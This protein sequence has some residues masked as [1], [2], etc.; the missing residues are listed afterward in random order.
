MLWVSSHER[1]VSSSL[2][3]KE[4]AQGIP[5]KHDPL[6]L[7]I[8]HEREGIQLA[9]QGT[10][11]MDATVVRGWIKCRAEKSLIRR[12]SDDFNL[13]TPMIRKGRGGDT[14]CDG[15][16]NFSFSKV[17]PEG[18]VLFGETAAHFALETDGRGNDLWTRNHG[19]CVSH[20]I[21][22]FMAALGIASHGE[23]ALSGFKRACYDL[24]HSSQRP[25]IKA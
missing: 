11:L 24:E 8:P 4:R 22:T 17:R 25:M 20:T 6:V 5:P 23:R 14:V 1:P 9:I 15:L 7:G 12:M 3:K 10:D 13:A 21:I 19:N 2:F 16:S 18:T